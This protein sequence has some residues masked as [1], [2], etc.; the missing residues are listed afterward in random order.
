MIQRGWLYETFCWKQETLRKRIYCIRLH[1]C[2]NCRTGKT[3]L[4]CKNDQKNGCL[5]GWV[6]AE[7]DLEGVCDPDIPYLDRSLV[8]QIYETQWMNNWEFCM[9]SDISFPSTGGLQGEGCQ[10]KHLVNKPKK[11]RSCYQST[12]W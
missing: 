1:S 7:I 9:S 6:G 3:N 2:C 11:W 12:H 10:E 4:W 5:W 8:T